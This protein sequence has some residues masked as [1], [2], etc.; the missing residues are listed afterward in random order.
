AQWSALFEPFMFFESYRNYLQVDIVAANTD[1]LRSWKGWVESR[2][3]RLTLMSSSRL[4]GTKNGYE[5]RCR[6]NSLK[7][8]CCC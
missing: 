1:N 2:L 3:R 4:G 5:V 7:R 8:I 6:D